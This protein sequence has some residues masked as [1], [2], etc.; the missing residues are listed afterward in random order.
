IEESVSRMFT[1]FNFSVERMSLIVYLTAVPFF[2]FSLWIAYEAYLKATS[3]GLEGVKVTAST[4]KSMLELFP[5]AL[6]LVVFG[7]IMDL[8]SEK[9]KFEIPKYGLY[10]I[11]VTILWFIFSVAVQWVLNIEPPYVYFSDVILAT[12]ISVAA[13]YF[14]IK[15]IKKIKVDVISR[16]RLENK[17][18]LSETGSYVGRII[19]VD[20]KESVIIVESPFGQRFQLPID[21]IS[22]IGD[23]VVVNY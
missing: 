21:A 11:S 14:S 15:V 16:M 4:L 22:S 8:M 6:L 5:W 23:R 9:K 13:A 7:K 1:K 12:I 20:S 2:L 19:G 3:S 10:A 18:V 17:E